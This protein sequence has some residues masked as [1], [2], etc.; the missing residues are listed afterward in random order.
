MGGPDVR[1]P[2]VRFPL[3]GVLEVVGVHLI[4]R[5]LVGLYGWRF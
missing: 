1:G 5:V 4:R 2:D 3:G